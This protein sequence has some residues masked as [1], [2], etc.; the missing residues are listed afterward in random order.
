MGLL[1]PT[2]AASNVGSLKNKLGIDEKRFAAAQHELTTTGLVIPV[3]K[4]RMGR[5][6]VGPEDLSI[7]AKVLLAALPCDGSTVG[8]YSVR[9]QLELDDETYASAKRELRDKGLIEVGVGYG[10]TV[11]R[12]SAI[13][14]AKADEEPTQAGLVKLEGELYEPF[15]D[16]L[17][18]YLQLDQELPFSCVRVT[19]T[20]KGR[21][22]SSGQ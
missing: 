11:S 19:A 17:Q 18:N 10:G 2:G 8:N 21:K 12:M 13:R 3:G 7:E 1:P 22:R 4:G 5:A 9:S 6:S 20:P 16:W 15:K 14:T